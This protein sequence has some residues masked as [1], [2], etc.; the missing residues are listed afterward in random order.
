MSNGFLFFQSFVFKKIEIIIHFSYSENFLM[1]VFSSE[2]TI[3]I[4]KEAQTPKTLT[5]NLI[6]E[7]SSLA[8]CFWKVCF[9]LK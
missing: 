3:K 9:Q 5:P 8:K 6:S 2:F 7:A 4:K 1:Q